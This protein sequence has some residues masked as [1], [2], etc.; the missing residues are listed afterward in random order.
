MSLAPRAVLVHRTTEYEELLAR[1]GTHGQAAFVLAGRGRSID[2]VAERHRRNE[3][4]LAEVAAAVPLRWRRSRVERADLDRFLFGPEDV[5]VVVGQD[6]LVANAAKYLSGQPV[7]GVDTDPGR[8][9]GVLVRHRA[10][11]TAALCRA[12][13]SP[14]A[15]VDAL[16]MTEAVADDTQRLLALNE[17][18]LGSPGHQTARYRIDIHGGP[19]AGESQASSGVL[20]G[21]G[22]GSTGWLRS[23]WL[24][25]GGPLPLPAPSDRRLVWFV[26]EAWPSP[27]TGTSMTVGELGLG[28]GLRLT[29]ESDR[30]V[31]FGDGMESDALELT[32][33]QSIRLGVSDTTLNLVA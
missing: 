3:Q 19:P 16:T 18:Y 14:G 5:V 12:A 8:N 6:G 29:V 15:R 30:M 27:A 32:W 9:P 23:L 21:T 22:T 25:R 28:D 31:V 10:R 13:V 11:D 20:V 33:G 24:E 17:I 4:A 7:V 1:H 26:R 2:E